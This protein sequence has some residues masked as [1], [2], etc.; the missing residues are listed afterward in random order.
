MHFHLHDLDNSKLDTPLFDKHANNR[1]LVTNFPH[2]SRPQPCHQRTM[3]PHLSWHLGA[4]TQFRSLHIQHIRP[5]ILRAQRRRRHLPMRSLYTHLHRRVLDHRL[6][7][8]GCGDDAGIWK[9]SVLLSISG[10]EARAVQGW[11]GR[12]SA[13][14]EDGA[15]GG[16][17]GREQEGVYTLLATEMPVM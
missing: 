17:K 2:S 5:A 15:V 3:V 13:I 12:L 10:D 14:R 4:S 1:V 8:G 9:G 7:I 16:R 11:T 6:S